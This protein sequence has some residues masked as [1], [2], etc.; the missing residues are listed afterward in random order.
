MHT[1]SFVCIDRVPP[2]VC[3]CVCVC[4][5]DRV[6]SVPFKALCQD[7]DLKDVGIL[8]RPR[9]KILYHISKRIQV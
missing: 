1:M 8:P 2:R 7:S 3:V 5:C 6:T 9:K 4:D